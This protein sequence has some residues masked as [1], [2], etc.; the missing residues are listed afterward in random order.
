MTFSKYFH[1][2]L[3]VF[4]SLGGFSQAPFQE[5]NIAYKYDVSGDLL[6]DHRLYFVDDSLLVI[7]SILPNEDTPTNW[8]SGF[9]LELN[10]K[11]DY[12]SS[13]IIAT[14]TINPGDY[15]VG[16]NGNYHVFQFKTGRR[17]DCKLI[18]LHLQHNTW[19]DDLLYD[20]NID[21]EAEYGHADLVLY[22][23]NTNIPILSQFVTPSSPFK[24][25][26]L[27][28]Q[29]KEIWIYRYD[30]DFDVAFPP[31][32]VDTDNINRT[33]SVASLTKSAT[34]TM[35]PLTES[36]LY[37]IQVDTNS[38]EGITFRIEDEPFPRFGNYHSLLKPL[39]YISTK[40]ENESME[41]EADDKKSFETFWL[42]TTGSPLTAQKSIKD[43]F[44]RVAGANLL[45][46][47]YKEGWKTDMGMMYIIYGPPDKVF[48]HEEYEQWIYNQNVNMPAIRFTFVKIK[49]V[50]STN[51]YSLVRDRKFDKHWFRAVE[52]WRQGKM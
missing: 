24:L 41:A 35:L 32:I 17:N 21:E 27:S 43:Y 30:T 42:T 14:E 1:L 7:L 52:L 44:E 40:T 51:H 5:E 8:N 34:D 28:G 25:K 11:K 18:Q 13:E 20:I 22:D 12:Q 15:Y 16:K 46:T 29:K 48:K 2:F 36:G 47:S 38:L 39:K 6:M 50:F 45:F 23:D 33:L 10:Y 26:H 3:F 37:F 31:M 19:P 9:T 49:N 4:I